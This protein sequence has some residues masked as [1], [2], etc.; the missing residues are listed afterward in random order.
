MCWWNL[1]FYNFASASIKNIFK[2]S[3]NTWFACSRNWFSHAV[4]HIT[5]SILCYY[6]LFAFNSKLRL[7][8]HDF[9]ASFKDQT[10]FHNVLSNRVWPAHLWQRPGGTGRGVWLRLQRSV[11]GPV[12]LWRQPARQQEV[13]TKAQ[14]SLQ[15]GVTPPHPNQSYFCSIL[16]FIYS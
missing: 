7:Y 2:P 13:Q 8:F 3:H 14:Q 15:V 9:T 10:E 16:W 11:Q 6:R 12:L 4:S 1:I 5:P